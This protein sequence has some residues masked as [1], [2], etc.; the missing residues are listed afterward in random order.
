M[1]FK[2]TMKAMN[3]NYFVVKFGYCEIQ[4][5]LHGKEPIAYSSGVYGWNCDYYSTLYPWIVICTG[6]RPTG[7]RV[8]EYGRS[9]YYEEQA[10]KIEYDY[11]IPYEERSKKLEK[12][13]IQFCKELYEK[14]KEFLS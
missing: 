5:L 12:L 3:E 6:Y 4:T 7:N 14:R 10:Q 1:K 13:F 2:T 9:T 8:L 11:S